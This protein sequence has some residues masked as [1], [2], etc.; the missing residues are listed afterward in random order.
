MKYKISTLK[1]NYNG[2]G[3]FQY[4]I[5]P[6]PRISWHPNGQDDRESWFIQV[7]EWAWDTLGPSAEIEFVITK[8][9]QARWGWQSSYEKLRIYLKS[10]A[11]LA[12]F[13]LRWL[14]S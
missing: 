13:N 5:E 4:F 8:R 3:F 1:S 14:D 12:L 2:Y 10:D 9:S 7:R 11:E 6:N